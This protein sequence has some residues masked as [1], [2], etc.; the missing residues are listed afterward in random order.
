MDNTSWPLPEP[1]TGVRLRRS[2]NNSWPSGPI[3]A[4]PIRHLPLSVWDPGLRHVGHHEECCHHTPLDIVRARDPT[5]LYTPTP[6]PRVRQDSPPFCYQYLPTL[7]PQPLASPGESGLPRTHI[8]EL[9]STPAIPA[10]P[11]LSLSRKHLR[12][13]PDPVARTASPYTD[14]SVKGPR[15]KLQASGRS[16]AANSKYAVTQAVCRH[17]WLLAFLLLTQAPSIQCSSTLST[18]PASIPG[19]SC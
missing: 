6:L 10:N 1:L 18:R 8:A 12:T 2:G 17:S 9:E 13:M 15:S 14:P 16:L 5:S 19:V 3:T 7:Q 11:I 4:D